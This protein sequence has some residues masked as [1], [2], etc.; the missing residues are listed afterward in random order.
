MQ[1][2]IVCKL[3]KAKLNVCNSWQNC[4]HSFVNCSTAFNLSISDL[5]IY[6]YLTEEVRDLILRSML[7]KQRPVSKIY[8]LKAL[9]RSP[10]VAC[11]ILLYSSALPHDGPVTWHYRDC[12]FA[13]GDDPMYDPE[14]VWQSL[15]CRDRVFTASWRQLSNNWYEL[16][17]LTLHSNQKEW[18]KI[19][20]LA[21][22]YIWV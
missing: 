3:L 22:R 14:W 19:I 1:Y 10:L 5:L 11:V 9:D 16:L 20:A 7:W 21:A 18:K 13:D 4:K 15:Q 8:Q 17:P 12:L 2:N 6:A